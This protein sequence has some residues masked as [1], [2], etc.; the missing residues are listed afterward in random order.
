MCVNTALL[1]GQFTLARREVRTQKCCQNVCTI[2]G[3]L[4]QAGGVQVKL[5]PA[6]VF[7]PARY[8]AAP[9]SVYGLEQD[10]LVS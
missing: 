3:R 8:A 9:V 6:R 2:R 5:S 1:T 10:G 4:V 7:A